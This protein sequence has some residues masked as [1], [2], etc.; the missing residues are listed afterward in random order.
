MKICQ[1]AG[2]GFGWHFAT[3]YLILP[4]SI[5][6]GAYDA[7]SALDKDMNLDFLGLVCV[8]YC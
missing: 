2:F 6:L 1:Q 7:I 3:S 5:N 4:F 8:F